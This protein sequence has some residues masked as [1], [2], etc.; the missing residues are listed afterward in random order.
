MEKPYFPPLVR[1]LDLRMDTSFCLSGTLEDTFD[2]PLDWD[3]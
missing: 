3:V 2:E 1:V